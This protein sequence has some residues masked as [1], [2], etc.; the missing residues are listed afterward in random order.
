MQSRRFTLTA[1]LCLIEEK[2]IIFLVF[3]S[4]PSSKTNVKTENLSTYNN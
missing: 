1:Q 4:I 2:K 3:D